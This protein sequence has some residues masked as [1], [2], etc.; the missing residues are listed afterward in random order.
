MEEHK[1]IGKI[2][3]KIKPKTI[4]HL[5]AYGS[6]PHQ[7]NFNKIKSINYNSSINLLNECS[8]YKFA[9]FINTGSSSEYGNKTKKMKEND[10]LEPISY[11]GLFKAAF[12]LYAQTKAKKE[13]LPIV[14]V[15]PFH[16]YG[17]GE[18]ATRMIPTIIQYLGR[19]VCPPLVSPKITRDMIYIDDVIKFYI[20]TSVKKN[21]NGQIF[22]IGSGKKYSIETIF[23]ELKKIMHSKTKAKWSTMKNRDHD[24]KIWY[25]DM[26]KTKRKFKFK[27]SYTLKAGLKKTFEHLNKK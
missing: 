4:F 21:I 26:S 7:K 19:N 27:N 17:P 11:Y 13:N 22:N 2:I 3:K 18:E 24:N 10:K 1:K 15:R 12:T 9:K 6:Y 25:A 23:E 16:V 20:M 14:S 8:K 5:A